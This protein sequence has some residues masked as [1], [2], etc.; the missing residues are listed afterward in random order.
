M[1]RMSVVFNST[2]SG[3]NMTG[4]T[5]KLNAV[6]GAERTIL[7][8]ELITV[9]ERVLSHT[10]RKALTDDELALHCAETITYHYTLHCLGVSWGVT[11][12]VAI[13]EEDLV[14]EY[15]DGIYTLV[16]E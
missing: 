9:R 15:K 2:T 3:G 1:D 8:H 16:V 14:T 13:P 4:L 6:N 11:D 10:D 12:H 5:F 7:G